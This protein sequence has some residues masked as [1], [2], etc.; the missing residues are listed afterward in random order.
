MTRR[1]RLADCGAF[2]E[3]EEHTGMT[4]SEAEL[5]A[6]EQQADLAGLP[7][8][9]YLARSLHRLKVAQAK[10]RGEGVTKH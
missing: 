1:E 10:L 3:F 4:M 9:D 2:H 6:F 5:E 7:L 8:C